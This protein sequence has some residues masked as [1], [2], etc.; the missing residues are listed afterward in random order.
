[1]PLTCADRVSATEL[2]RCASSAARVMAARA[3]SGLADE[4][5]P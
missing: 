5:E 2:T 1:L 4:A 3:L